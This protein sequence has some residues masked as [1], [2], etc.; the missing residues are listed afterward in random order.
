MLKYRV[1]FHAFIVTSIEMYYQFAK[2]L[3]SSE[4]PIQ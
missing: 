2:L 3:C 4:K 1:T